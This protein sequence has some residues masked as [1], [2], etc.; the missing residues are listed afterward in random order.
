MMLVIYAVK[1]FAYFIFSEDVPPQPNPLPSHREETPKMSVSIR[2]MLPQ[3][4]RKVLTQ[5]LR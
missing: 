5:M 4:I 1:I 3:E 2:Y